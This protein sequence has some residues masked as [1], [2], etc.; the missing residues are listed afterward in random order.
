MLSAEYIPDAVPCRKSAEALAVDLSRCGCRGLPRRILW[1]WSLG[2]QASLTCPGATRAATK[3]KHAFTLVKVFLIVAMPRSPRH[4]SI[5]IIEAPSAR[6]LTAKGVSP[7]TRRPRIRSTVSAKARV[8][9]G[10]S[11]TPSGS[12]TPSGCDAFGIRHQAVTRP[13]TF[14]IEGEP[15]RCRRSPNCRR[16]S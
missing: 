16:S 12:G 8:T 3:S 6:R 5:A 4:G 15:R 2:G 11:E 1:R 14:Q 13:T 9:S 10:C 7:G